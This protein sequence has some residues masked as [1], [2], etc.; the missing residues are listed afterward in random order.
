MVFVALSRATA[1]RLHGCFVE[2]SPGTALAAPG[3]KT[4]SS[5]VDCTPASP[6]NRRTH[7]SGEEVTPSTPAGGLQRRAM[8]PLAAK[9]PALLTATRPAL[10]TKRSHT[11]VVR[12]SGVVFVVFLSMRSRRMGTALSGRVPQGA[13]EDGVTKSGNP[14][15]P[16]KNEPLRRRRGAM[17]A[18]MPLTGRRLYGQLKEPPAALCAVRSRR[19]ALTKARQRCPVPPSGAD[20]WERGASDKCTASDREAHANACLSV[21]ALS[22]GLCVA[23]TDQNRLLRRPVPP[24]AAETRGR[25]GLR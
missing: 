19:A 20:S 11:Q 13:A 7:C 17:S 16:R 4:Q 8:Y 22:G 15:E 21:H 2:L 12:C 3:G 23:G 18:A 1:R 6:T 24:S 14:I 10:H 9:G 25:G 5:R